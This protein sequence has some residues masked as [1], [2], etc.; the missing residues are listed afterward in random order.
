MLIEVR[1]TRMKHMGMEPS[2]E[3]GDPRRVREELEWCRRLF[4][5]H[6][7]WTLLEISGKAIEETASLILERYRQRFSHPGPATPTRPAAE[8]PPAVAA[9]AQ[10]APPTRPAP[11]P[12]AA[13]PVAGKP[14]LAKHATS[15]HGTARPAAKPVEQAGA[16][17]AVKP[18]MKPAVKP[19][20][21]PMVGPARRSG[22]KP[23]AK[24]AKG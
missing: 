3:Y 2:S 9:D 5:D 22:P 8:P 10:A 4:A 17:P 19:A 11:E 18:A 6:P 24:K 23:T 20:V 13:M 7:Q 1:R 14:V 12:V 15:T 21:K 16:K